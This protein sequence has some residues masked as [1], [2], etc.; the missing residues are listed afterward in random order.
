MSRESLIGLEQPLSFEFSS[1]VFAGF[2]VCPLLGVEDLVLRFQ[3]VRGVSDAL[4]APMT[5]RPQ[6]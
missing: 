5:Y 1:L 2:G 4:G 3:D 6:G